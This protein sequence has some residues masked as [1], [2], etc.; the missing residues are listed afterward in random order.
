M[1]QEA[2]RWLDEAAP[3]RRELAKTYPPA[4]WLRMPL[5]REET[6]RSAQGRQACLAKPAS[7]YAGLMLVK[8]VLERWPDLPEAKEAEKLL[9]EY[10]A[11]KDKPWEADDIAEHVVTLSPR[12]AASMPT[13]S[14]LPKEYVKYLA[15]LKQAIALWKQ[16]QRTGSI[17]RPAR[18]PRNASRNWKSSWPT[19][20]HLSCVRCVEWRI[21]RLCEC[22]RSAAAAGPAD[23][24]DS[25]A[26]VAVL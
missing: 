11:R 5:S 19:R 1:L 22:H 20:R 24:S 21:A 13:A 26:P 4:A 23:F 9:L 17:Q 15:M 12:P 10:E 7:I 2:I 14:N 18:K 16:V 8:G 25:P 3:K 6:A